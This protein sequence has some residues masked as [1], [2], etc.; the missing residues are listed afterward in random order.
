VRF[1]FALPTEIVFGPGVLAQLG[2]RAASLGQRAFLVTGGG[3]LEKQGVVTRVETMMR[4]HGVSSNRFAS[5]GEPDTES[6]DRAARAARGEGSDLVIGLGGGSALD[7]AKAVACLL[8]NRGESLD[9]IEVVGRGQPI[10]KPS[11]PFI[12]IPSTGGTGSETTKNAVLTHRA[13]RTKAS[14]R[15]PHMMARLALVDPELSLSVPPAITA[16][17]GLDALTQLIEPYTSRRA[18]PMIDALVLGAM[19]HAARALPRAFATPGD[20]A[21]RSQMM[22]ASLI[23]GVALAHA[24]LGAAHAFS[25]P[26]G[27]SF[28]VPHG[29]ACAAVLPGVME[30]NLRRAA[31][32]GV[33]EAVRRYADVARAM[34]APSAS[35]DV[36][37]A[38][39]GIER[40]RGLCAHLQVPGLAA[41]GMTVADVPDLAQR[42]RLTS[43]MRA[44]PVDLSDDDLESILLGALGDHASH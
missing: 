14:L 9:Y 40:V 2:E 34:G 31:E 41:F 43:S 27:G 39:S 6:V 1:D 15:S 44:N 13:T 36:A 3:S 18:Q 19:V 42:S 11:L 30:T 7:T 21:A 28:P 29:F 24:G 23:S 8:A 38:H 26:L 37:T 32:A 22:Y 17:T 16:A 4:E 10:A 35:D 25:G 20:L 33:T 12:A 5:R